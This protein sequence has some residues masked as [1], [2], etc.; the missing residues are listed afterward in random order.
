[1]TKISPASSIRR[2]VPGNGGPTEPIF[3]A[4]GRLTAVGA[5]VSVRP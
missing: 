5:V 1:L 4:S 2:L 3:S